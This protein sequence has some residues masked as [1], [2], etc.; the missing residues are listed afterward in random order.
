MAAILDYENGKTYW[1]RLRADLGQI[2]DP[3]VDGIPI[4]VKLAESA[5]KLAASPDSA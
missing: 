1:D 5:V 4:L 2:A 3:V